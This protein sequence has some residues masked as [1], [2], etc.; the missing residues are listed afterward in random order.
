MASETRKIGPGS[1]RAVVDEGSI[2]EEARTV[3]L[4]WTTGARVKRW[5]WDGPWLEELSLDPAHVRMGRLENGAPLL[6][7]HNARTTGSVI[8]VVESARLEA[9][10]GVATVRF[11]SGDP[12]VDRV[13]NKIS[14]RILRNVSVGY[15]THRAQLVEQAE[16]EPPVYRAVDWEPFELSIVPIGADAGAQVRAEE[17]QALR[18]CEFIHPQQNQEQRDMAKPNTPAP[19]APTPTDETRSPEKP[20][21]DIRAEN[22]RAKRQERERTEGIR[23]L[24]KA[25][26]CDEQFVRTH[27]DGE[28]ELVEFQ[29]LAVD[30][31][32]TRQPP[33]VPDTARITAGE[34]VADKRGRCMVAS[35]LVRSG[36]AGRCKIEG[37]DADPG[38]FRSHTLLDLAAA[39]L[40]AAGISTEGKSRKQIAGMALTMGM[41]RSQQSTSDFP[42]VLEEALHKTLL[43]AYSVT[44]D[45]WRR[46][47]AVGS[48][49]DFREH[50]RYR[51]GTLGS[52]PIVPEGSEYKNTQ[53]SDARKETISANTHGNIVAIT[54]QAIINDDMG[55]FLSITRQMGRAAKLTEEELV[56]ALLAENSGLGPLMND[57]L[58]LFDA[59]HN[60]IGTGSALS[61]AGIDGD[62]VVMAEQTDESGNEVLDLRPQV[63]VLAIGLG[64]DARVINDAQFDVDEVA[65]NSTNMFHKPNKVRGLFRD[66][67]DTSRLSGTRRYLF[68]DPNDVPTLEVVFLDGREAPMLESQAGWRVDGTEFKVSHDVGADAVDYRGAVTNAGS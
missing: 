67:V 5:G 52:L 25:L 28:T 27:I 48:V 36:M 15:D 2:N 18:L 35:I 53:I 26:G 23:R 37:A 16:G 17:G 39:S 41:Q 64:G 29:R 45:T 1:I 51:M 56:Y 54:R 50:N 38:E 30:H 21:T 43:G 68:A 65:A 14:Q 61:V 44:P 9:E 19:T 66:I 13:W 57:G 8:G 32:E 40:R 4:V 42:V 12:D 62:R 7:S 3:D 58:P 46:F 6:D 10:R 59:S 47:C 31:A 20:E 55:A 49:S 24:G 60:N 63:L 11:P 33:V 22:E 34:D